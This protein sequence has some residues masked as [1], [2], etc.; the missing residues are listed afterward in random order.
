MSLKQSNET[1]AFLA[2]QSASTRAMLEK[3]P[4]LM[5]TMQRAAESK[6]KIVAAIPAEEPKPEPAPVAQIAQNPVTMSAMQKR[7]ET[8]ALAMSGKVDKETGRPRK[9]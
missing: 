5:V 7:N 6:V 8:I 3:H 4:D 1:E 9:W 2:T